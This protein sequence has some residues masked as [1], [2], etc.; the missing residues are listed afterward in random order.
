MCLCPSLRCCSASVGGPRFDR[1]LTPFEL[2]TGQ[3]ALDS[4]ETGIKGELQN[5]TI[6]Q[7]TQRPRGGLRFSAAGAAVWLEALVSMRAGY[8]A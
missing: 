6:E 4:G 1:A 7:A 8:G 3:I 2:L 5:R